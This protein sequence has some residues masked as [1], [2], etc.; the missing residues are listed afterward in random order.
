MLDERGGLR[1]I[2]AR[3]PAEETG[4]FCAHRGWSHIREQ[5]CMWAGRRSS[6]DEFSHQEDKQEPFVRPRMKLTCDDPAG[7]YSPPAIRSTV[8]LT[9]DAWS[10]S[11][12]TT[13]SAISP[14]CA[15][16]AAGTRATTREGR[17]GSPAA[18]WMSV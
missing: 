8:A 1:P 3:T 10:D 17:S 18:A 11:S 5:R 2:A 6:I 9:Y 4:L 7:R 12:Q 13:P 16:R 14:G 15:M